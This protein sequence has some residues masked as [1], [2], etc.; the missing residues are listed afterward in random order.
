MTEF[1]E[2]KFLVSL[3][4]V[5]PID[6]LSGWEVFELMVNA[7]HVTGD[8]WMYE[9]DV[10]MLNVHG[11]DEVEQGE[12]VAHGDMPDDDFEKHARTVFEIEF[13]GC[14]PAWKMLTDRC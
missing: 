2:L 9:G 6:E 5:P 10:E 14:D 11:V 1:T 4:K 12:T 7:R 3:I 13:D 8:Y